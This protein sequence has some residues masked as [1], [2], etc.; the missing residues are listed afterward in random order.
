M[1]Q[2][3]ISKV[4]WRLF[5]ACPLFGACLALWRV[6]RNRLARLAPLAPKPIV[7]RLAMSLLEMHCPNF[8][9]RLF[10]TC[11]LFGASS[12]LGHLWRRLAPGL[13]SNG[14][15]TVSSASH[16]QPQ[17]VSG[18][19]MSSC[20]ATLLAFGILSYVLIQHMNSLA[21]DPHTDAILLLV[22]TGSSALPGHCAPTEMHT[23]TFRHTGS[24]P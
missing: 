7:W 3:C 9:W 19:Q 6:W 18:T 11:P 20:W 8:V 5:G 22:A 21:M 2:A 23:K 1:L 14:N 10:G 16:Q 13:V 15:T 12:A 4:V 24:Q 17:T